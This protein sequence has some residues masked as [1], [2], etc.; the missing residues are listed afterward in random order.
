[1]LCSYKLNESEESWRDLHWQEKCSQADR[2]G[3]FCCV[4]SVVILVIYPKNSNS[5][6]KSVDSVISADDGNFC[7]ICRGRGIAFFQ[8]GQ[9]TADEVMCIQGRRNRTG[10]GGHGRP[11]FSAVFLFFY[12]F[13]FFSTLQQSARDDLSANVA[14][15]CPRSWFVAESKVHVH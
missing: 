8:R 5:A 6:G 10:R 12:F 2:K 9:F 3:V 15:P 11:T 13:I 4:L 14:N 1:M 7:E